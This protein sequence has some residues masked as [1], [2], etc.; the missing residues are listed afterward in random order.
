MDKQKFIDQL[1]KLVAFETVTGNFEANSRALDYVQTLLEE[2]VVLKRVKNKNAEILIASNV[3]TN[4]PNVAF[5]VHMDV[6][7]AKKEQFS[8]VQKGDKLFGRGASDM[9]FSIPMG[10]SL[11][12]DLVAK[13][14]KL[15]FALVI[16]TD[17]EVGGFDGGAF[18][19]E[20]LKFRPKCLLVPDGG[21]N[22]VFVEKAKGVCQVLITSIGRP[23]HASRPWMGKNAIDPL[24]KLSVRLLKLYDKNSLKETW[25]T[26]MNIG[27]IQGGMSTNQVCAEAS[28]KLDFRYPETD[29]IKNILG[30]VTKL[31]K[32]IEPSLKVSTM[33][34]GLPTFTNR[35]ETV[36]QDFL[37]SMET[38]FGKKIIVD[39]TYGASDARHFAKYNIP[40]LMM[41]PMGG[42]IHSETEWISIKSSMK[43]YMGLKLFLERISKNERN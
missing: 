33:S 17:E 12:N 3:K 41:K 43:F 15:S 42:E 10:V 7:S 19:A 38:A 2:S 18:L 28:L 29:S 20:N 39:K 14:S 5:M 24:T 30:I 25:N 13:K 36:V 1:K 32:K 40:V 22:L 37:A 23:A 6:V 34:T 4:S 21:D 9:K 8:L 16:T 31:C 11:L 27:Q 26:T 35:K